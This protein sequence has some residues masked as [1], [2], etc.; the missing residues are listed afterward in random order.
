[1]IVTPYI[2]EVRTNRLSTGAEVSWG[3]IPTMG[4][5]HEGHLSLVRRAG[6]ENDK[7]IVSIYINPTQFSPTEDLA[8]YP[9]DL[10]RDLRLLQDAGVDIVFT[11][12]DDELYPDD[13]QTFVTVNRSAKPLEGASRPTHFQGVTTVVAKLFNI[14]QPQ[15]VYFGQKDAQQC[16]VVRQMIKDLNFDLEMVVCPTVREADGLALSSRNRYL[17]EEERRIAPV[18]FKAL[19]TAREAYLA[20]ERNG[21]TLRNIMSDFIGNEPLARIDYVSAADPISLKE[22]NQIK[23]GVLLSLAVF[24]G[25]TRLIDN[26]LMQ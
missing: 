8:S 20:G 3:F 25:K 11:P 17:S 12:S 24:F 4:Y 18:L 10:D 16:V 14:V 26:I 1:M 5:L 2:N 23:Q 13:F 9:R 7:V 21:Q 15:R 6:L 19:S 22:I